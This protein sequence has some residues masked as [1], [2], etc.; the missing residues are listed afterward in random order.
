MT[1]HEPAITARPN[2]QDIYHF[3]A[4]E[5][6]PY[7][8]ELLQ[9]RRASRTATEND[10][11]DTISP[12]ILKALLTGDPQTNTQTQTSQHTTKPTTE[13]INHNTQQPKTQQTHHK[14]QHNQTKHPNNTT[15]YHK[16][17]ERSNIA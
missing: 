9:R 6:D 8:T 4:Y 5:T 16:P 1:K 14:Q 15:Q 3:T 17:V 2:Q 13:Q 12:V 7:L 10:I 11:I